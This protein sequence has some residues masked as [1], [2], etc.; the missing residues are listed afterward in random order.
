MNITALYASLRTTIGRGTSVDTSLPEW[1][2]EAIN[3]LET[4]ATYKW[5]EKSATLTVNP[6]AN[7]NVIA[8]P[9]VRVKAV[10]FARWGK[11]EGSNGAIVYGLP[12]AGVTAFDF[13]SVDEG[14]TAGGFYLDG[15]SNLVIDGIPAATSHL[16]VHYWEYT[17]WPTD[18]SQT[19]AILARHFAGVKAIVMNT[20]ARSL[21]DERLASVWQSTSARAEQAMWLSD[22]IDGQ[23]GMKHRRA[24]AQR[25]S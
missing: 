1:C 21:R 14:T 8:L 5:M 3:D 13:S 7:T 6:G 16:N 17:E 23:I 19:P 24:M 15:V 4:S 10:D 12:L 25:G 11:A 2:Q 22:G 20:A 9:S 18:P